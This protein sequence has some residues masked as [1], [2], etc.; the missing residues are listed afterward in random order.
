MKLLLLTL[1][2]FSAVF[3]SGSSSIYALTPGWTP[4]EDYREDAS[5]E[6]VIEPN[7]ENQEIEQPNDEKSLEDI[8]GSEQVFPFEPGFS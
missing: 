1:V 8:F 6:I 4:P 2:L 5:L 7:N 3:F